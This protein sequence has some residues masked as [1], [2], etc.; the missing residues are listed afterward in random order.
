MRKGPAVASRTAA[1]AR[2]LALLL[3]VSYICPVSAWPEQVGSAAPSFG[4]A[5]ANGKKIRPEDLGGKVLLLNFWA[6]WCAS[7][8]IELPALESLHRKYRD[9]GLLVIGISEDASETAVRKVARKS[10]LSYLMLIDKGGKVADAFR[11][12]GLPTTFIVDRAGIVRYRHAGFAGEFRLLYEEETAELLRQSKPLY[13]E[14]T[15]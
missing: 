10:G 4:L 9:A 7:C 13:P 2:T 6:P 3:A 1:A 15:Q 14:V 5:D 12:S 11:V 8:R